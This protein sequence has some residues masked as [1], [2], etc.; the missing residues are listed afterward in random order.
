[1]TLTATA[2]RDTQKAICQILGMVSPALV[3]KMPNR[4]NVK[5]IVRADPGTL[6]ESFSS[7]VEEN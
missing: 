6:E 7:I 3:M 5:Y 2:T 1:M 4:P